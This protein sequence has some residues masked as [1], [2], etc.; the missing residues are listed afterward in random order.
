M[1]NGSKQDEAP[2]GLSEYESPAVVDLGSVRGATLG[3]ASTGSADMNGQFYV[4]WRQQEAGA[5]PVALAICG[6]AG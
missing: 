6:T 4:G 3:S 5:Q 1:N 2:A